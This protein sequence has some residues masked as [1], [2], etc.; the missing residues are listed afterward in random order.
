[1]KLL[2]KYSQTEE[3]SLRFVGD[4]NPNTWKGGL[5]TL[6]AER[7]ML[8]GLLELTDPNLATPI[9]GSFLGGIA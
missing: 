8:S 2:A 5:L 1:M 6:F 3:A 9:T 7:Q 4:F